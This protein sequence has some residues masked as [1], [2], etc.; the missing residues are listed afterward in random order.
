ML[1]QMAQKMTEMQMSGFYLSDH[2]PMGD[3]GINPINRTVD[4]QSSKHQL[5]FQQ[6]LHYSVWSFTRREV[7]SEKL[8]DVKFLV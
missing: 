8:Q 5:E 7:T 2:R 1:R 3:L 6:H 4:K